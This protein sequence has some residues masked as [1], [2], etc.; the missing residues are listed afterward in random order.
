M[1]EKHKA[2]EQF[3]NYINQPE[4]REEVCKIIFEHLTKDFCHVSDVKLGDRCVFNKI[5]NMEME[6][7]KERS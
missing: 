3:Y 2:F 7:R 5:N 6:Q 4:I 1:E